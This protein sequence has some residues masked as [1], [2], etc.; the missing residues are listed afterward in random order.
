MIRKM[1]FFS[2]SSPYVPQKYWIGQRAITSRCMGPRRSTRSLSQT[3]QLPTRLISHTGDSHLI[4][5]AYLHTAQT[6]GIH[7]W[8][9]P[10]CFSSAYGKERPQHCIALPSK[11]S[12]H[13]S[14]VLWL[15]I[16]HLDRGAL[17]K[18]SA[19]PG[20]RSLRGCPKIQGPKV[21]LKPALLARSISE[22]R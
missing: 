21:P 13:C 3:A 5:S 19:A 11:E 15:L 9:N 1:L 17:T 8:P 2:K 14:I 4:F 20:W 18:W 22:G 16:P 6:P 12:Q 7:N 10:L